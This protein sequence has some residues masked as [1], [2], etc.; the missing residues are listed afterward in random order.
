MNKPERVLN[1]EGV[2]HS[3]TQRA[4]MMLLLVL[5]SVLTS[6]SVLRTPQKVVEAVVPART[7]EPNLVQLQIELQRFSDDFAGRTTQALDDY[8]EK[9]GTEQARIL[10]LQLKL[11]SLSAMISVVSGPNPNANLLD[12]VTINTLTRRMV[13]DYWM[14]TPGGQHF[15]AWLEN[16]R[17]L[18]TNAWSLAAQV[19]KPEQIHELRASINKWY[20]QNPQLRDGFLARPHE[21]VGMMAKEHKGTPNINSVF[22]FVG[23]DPTIGLDPAVREVTQTRLF[24]ERAMFTLQRMPFLLRFQTELLAYQLVDIPEVRL[25]LTNTVSISQSA[26]RI[27]RTTAELPELITT[28]RKAI[29]AAMEQQEGKLR[30]LSDSLNQTLISAER[31]STSLNTTIT[32]FDALMKRFGVGEPDTNS[33]PDTNSP[34]FNILDYGK[35][36]DQ[37]AGMAK[38]L[39]VLLTTANSNVTQLTQLSDGAAKRADRLVDRAFHRG[40]LLIVILL[41]GTVLAALTYRALTRKRTGN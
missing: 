13:E 18:E 10:A 17:I 3:A 4:S 9:T 35:V 30:E 24:A 21:L 32:T 14:K 33:V 7:A 20:E 36:A 37:I 27:S 2:F 8:A 31:M 34:P 6:C 28:E 41:V 15:E 29:L 16:A 26:E 38:E 25:V 23:I 39:N 12:L 11:R 1:P 22:S 19:L 5:L 40:I